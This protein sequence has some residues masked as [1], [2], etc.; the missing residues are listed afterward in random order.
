M[1]D[2]EAVGKE[3]EWE[4]VVEAGGAAEEKE[5]EVE[6]EDN[7]TDFE[8]SGCFISVAYFVGI[9]EFRFPTTKTFGSV[10]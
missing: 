3:R 1:G 8:N 10:I 2:G 7:A 9:S 4:E 6:V 5:A